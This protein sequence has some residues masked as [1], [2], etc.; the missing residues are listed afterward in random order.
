MSAPTRSSSRPPTARTA[1]AKPRRRSPSR[2]PVVTRSP[3]ATA[4]GFTS[5]ARA[6][7]PPGLSLRRADRVHQWMSRSTAS[8]SS[9][10]PQSL[11]AALA[12]RPRCCRSRRQRSWSGSSSPATPRLARATAPSAP[13]RS[14]TPTARPSRPGASLA[15]YQSS[16]REGESGGVGEIRELCELKLPISSSHAPPLSPSLLQEL[17]SFSEEDT[18]LV[19]VQPV[20]GVG[21]FDDA[22]VFDRVRSAVLLRG[23]RPAFH[24]P[25]QQHR[26]GDL[27]KDFPYVIMTQPVRREES[28]VIIELPHER[29]VSIPVR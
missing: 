25:E 24:P 9:R 28:R 19:V 6:A 7:L 1:A 29:P 12:S 3:A 14:S 11:S 10:G 15:C 2:L 17:R 27:A 26:A 21:D 22:A 8:S 5:A 18:K 20:A 23:E 16:L 13:L 4:S